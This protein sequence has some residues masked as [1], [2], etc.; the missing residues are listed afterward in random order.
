[1]SPAVHDAAA[2][3]LCLACS[4][5]GCLCDIHG[6]CGTCNYDFCEQHLCG[7]H[8]CKKADDVGDA[9]GMGIVDFPPTVSAVASLTAP[10]EPTAP[11]VQQQK[12]QQ[13][14]K[15][16]QDLYATIAKAVKKKTKLPKKRRD[17]ED[18]DD[19]GDD[20][21]FNLEDVATEAPRGTRTSAR[22]SRGASTKSRESSKGA[23][24]NAKDFT[25][26]PNELIWQHVW[27]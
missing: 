12:K 6:R 16:Q 27:R 3:S 5:P 25:K 23:L 26:C 24:S 9:E 7:D 8:A 14:Q 13:Q 2:A 20:S 18:S 17:G 11:A 1:M 4:S 15:Q 19:S 10:A 22:L 21:D